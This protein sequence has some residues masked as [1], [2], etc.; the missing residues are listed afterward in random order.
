MT[1]DDIENRMR[2]VMVVGD[3]PV[4]DPFEVSELLI[5]EL[6]NHGDQFSEHTYATVMG[7]AIILRKHYVDKLMSRFE[8]TS[9]ISKLR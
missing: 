5:S 8:T 1:R 4:C 3:L 6:V 7:A 9:L 2:Q